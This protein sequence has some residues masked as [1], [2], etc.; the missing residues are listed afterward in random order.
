MKIILIL[1]LY[2][3]SHIYG[4]KDSITKTIFF[5]DIQSTSYIV[6]DASSAGG[7]ALHITNPQ[8]ASSLNVE[9]SMIDLIVS[10]NLTKG[11][12]TKLER[13]TFS[14]YDLD[15]LKEG[16]YLYFAISSH[17]ESILYLQ[18]LRKTSTEVLIY[19]IAI[20]ENQNILRLKKEDFF[21]KIL[22]NLTGTGFRKLR[23][24]RNYSTEFWKNIRLQC[25]PSPKLEILS[26]ECILDNILKST[27]KNTILEKLNRNI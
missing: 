16:S 24:S 13:Q 4:Q 2:P 21:Y 5:A 27:E 9:P 26:L 19:P 18:V 20:K 17:K 7:E 3:I 25:T 10:E 22:T 12:F 11:N 23:D 1:L 6:Q 15:T 14:D 8:I